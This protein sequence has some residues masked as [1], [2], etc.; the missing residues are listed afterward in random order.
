MYKKYPECFVADGSDAISKLLTNCFE[1]TIPTSLKELQKDTDH[2][3]T[4][5]IVRGLTE[6]K[7]MKVA[8]EQNRTFYYIDTGYM[9][10]LQKRKD[11]HRVVKNDVQHFSPRWDLPK[12]RF[13]RL[14]GAIDKLRFRGWKNHNGPILVVTP[15][16]KP[17]MYYGITRDQWLTE[18]MAELKKHT[19]REIIVRDKVGR[20]LRVGD[21]SVPAQIDREKIYALV[22]YNSIA[23]TE[24]ISSGIPAIATAPGAA[25]A[26]CTKNISDI[27]N[28]Y[29]PDPDKVVAWQNWLAYCNFNTRELEDGTALAII[30]EYGLC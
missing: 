9:G 21:N 8:T 15:S 19:D 1:K 11:W 25:D 16:E 13:I 2:P 18:T 20:V 24:A 7:V 3:H 14:P 17:C 27:E 22:T 30:E 26:L 12:D 23:A 29:R 28:P 10:N 6:R 5:V 4:P